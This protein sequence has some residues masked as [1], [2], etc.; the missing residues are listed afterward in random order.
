MRL[1]DI[2]V[3]KSPRVITLRQRSGDGVALSWCAQGQSVSP[4][5]KCVPKGKLCA[6]GQSVSPRAK[7]VPKGKVCAQGQSVCPR[8]KC[9]PKGKVCAQGQS[10]SPRAKCEPRGKV[11]AQGQSVCP[12]AKCT[13]PWA[14]LAIMLHNNVC[15][16]CPLLQRTVTAL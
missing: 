9:V 15:M 8:A 14:L 11:C 6:Q 16:C 5:A 13:L 4:R 3:T 7:C 12:R 2:C 10:V 1:A